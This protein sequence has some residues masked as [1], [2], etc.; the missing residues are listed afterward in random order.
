LIEKNNYK[1]N[2]GKKNSDMFDFKMMNYD[3]EGFDKDDWGNGYRDNNHI[4]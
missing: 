1:E 4:H 2:K 3:N